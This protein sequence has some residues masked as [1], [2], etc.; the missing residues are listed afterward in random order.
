MKK[1]IFRHCLCCLLL[2]AAAACGPRERTVVLLSTNDIHACIQRFP[3][4][5]AAVKACRDTADVVFLIDAGDRWTGNA[6]VD[7]AENRRPVL[8]LMNRLGYDAATLGNHEFDAGHAVLGDM[9]RFAEFP[10]VCAN[11]RSDTA[12]VPQTP[13]GVVVEKDGVMR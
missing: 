6:Y 10:V 7:L 2:A 11:L 8:E 1:K 12:A 3:Q 5:A 4:L 9:L 13:P